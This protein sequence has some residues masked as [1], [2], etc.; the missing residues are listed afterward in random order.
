MPDRSAQTIRNFSLELWQDLVLLDV[1]K[2]SF[3]HLTVT[4]SFNVLE[5]APKP[6]IL[7][8]VSPGQLYYLFLDISPPD[9]PKYF[10]DKQILGNLKIWFTDQK[11]KASLF[12]SAGT[13][14]GPES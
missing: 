12:V 11:V 3:Q 1:R 2:S 8:K 6:S 7:S 9:F 14:C 5:M 10:A 4:W 13:V